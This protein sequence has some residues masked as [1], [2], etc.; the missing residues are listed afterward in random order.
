MKK[1]QIKIVIVDVLQKTLTGQLKS[2][3]T[4]NPQHVADA[5][6]QKIEFGNTVE[7]T[8]TNE[9]IETIIE[10]LENCKK[11][12]DDEF[13]KL[14]PKTDT[15]LRN[16]VRGKSHAYQELLDILNKI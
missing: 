7:D 12:I 15:L 14:D 6:N 1:N 8:S 13:E 16:F 10:S 3:S 5:I 9:V 4:F 11:E 2:D